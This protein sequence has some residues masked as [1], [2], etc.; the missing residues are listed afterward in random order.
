MPVAELASPSTP[1]P[2][3]CISTSSATPSPRLVRLIDFGM[4]MH[5]TWM[6]EG[7]FEEYRAEDV[8]NAKRVLFP[9]R[10]SACPYHADDHAPTK[11]HE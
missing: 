5:R 2:L 7:W 11:D 8:H 1:P 6:S 10:S 4:A 9:L 3:S